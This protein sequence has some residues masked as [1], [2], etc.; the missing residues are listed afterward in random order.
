MQNP[1]IDDHSKSMQVQIGNVVSHFCVNVLS[2]ICDFAVSHAQC[3]ATSMVGG[4]WTC[5]VTFTRHQLCETV[6]VNFMCC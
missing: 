1:V 5:D 2:H 3:R 6:F 4:G